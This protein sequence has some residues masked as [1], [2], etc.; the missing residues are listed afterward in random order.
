M[1]LISGSRDEMLGYDVLYIETSV[2]IDAL[3]ITVSKLVSP[4][5][6]GFIS[7]SSVIT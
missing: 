7:R 2:Q 1:C 5:N 3:A 6:V 4:L